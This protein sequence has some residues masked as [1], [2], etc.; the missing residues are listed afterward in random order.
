M[1]PA[2]VPDQ[3]ALSGARPSRASWRWRQGLFGSVVNS[4][5]KEKGTAIVTMK[6]LSPGVLEVTGHG[7][8]DV[9]VDAKGA[10][11]VRFNVETAC[12]QQRASR[13][14]SSS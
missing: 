5:L 1:G 11:E 6:S 4:Q 7:A 2:R 14:R 13:C 3:Q 12:R 8:T 9:E 10:S